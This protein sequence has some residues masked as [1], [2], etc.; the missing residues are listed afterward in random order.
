MVWEAN[1]A[2]L[3][4][5]KAFSLEKYSRK[6]RTENGK[7]KKQKIT[8]KRFFCKIISRQSNGAIKACSIF[9]CNIYN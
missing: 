5:I 8:F 1:C 9:T 6:Y 4:H 3:I 2:I 7:T